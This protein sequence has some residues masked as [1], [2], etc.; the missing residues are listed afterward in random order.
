MRQPRGTSRRYRSRGVSRQ[1]R[2]G[3]DR[4]RDVCCLDVSSCLATV[5]LKA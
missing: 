5:Y 1:H 2:K 3:E 4:R